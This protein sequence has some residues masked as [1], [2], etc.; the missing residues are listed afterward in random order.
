MMMMMELPSRLHQVPLRRPAGWAAPSLGVV[1]L[2][3][4]LLALG[5]LLPSSSPELLTSLVLS[6]M[7]IYRGYGASVT[8][9]S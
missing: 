1:L 2:L 4:P 8:I 3:L 9:L 7:P 5:R 6:S